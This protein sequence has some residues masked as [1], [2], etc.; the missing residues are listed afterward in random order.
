MFDVIILDGGINNQLPADAS[1]FEGA[2][3]QYA[4]G[5][6]TGVPVTF[7]STG[8][9]PDEVFTEMVDQAQFL[10]RW[11]HRFQ[12]RRPRGFWDVFKRPVYQ[13]VAVNGYLESTGNTNSTAFN[14]TGRAGMFSSHCILGAPPN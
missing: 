9:L 4:I 12:A 7:I 13:D 5:L 8:I 6:R 11:R 1:I 14:V 3:I 2:E 10:V